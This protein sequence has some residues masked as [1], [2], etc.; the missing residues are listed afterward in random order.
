[1]Q[2]AAAAAG[3]NSS[4]VSLPANEW[5]AP[6][7]RAPA[8]EAYGSTI[9]SFEFE[10]SAEIPRYEV[11][12]RSLPGLGIAHSTSS[13]SRVRRTA[14]HLV[15]DDLVLRINLAGVRTL[16]QCG[17]EATVGP[18]EAVLSSGAEIS[19]ATTTESCFISFRVPCKPIKALVPDVEDRLCRTIAHETPT[20]RLL[21][22]YADALQDGP[23]ILAPGLQHLTVTHVYDLIALTLGATGEASEQAR[24]RGARAARL[25][26]IK[27]DIEQNLSAP[28][29][30]IGTVA[31]R[32]RLPVR[33]VQRLFEAEGATFTEFLL[34]RR[35]TRVHR[36]LSDP[37]L[38]DRPI[39]LLAFEAGFARQRYFNR[40]FRARFGAT[41][42]DIRAQTQV[43]RES[44]AAGE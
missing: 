31:E 39:S 11:K 20:L 19:A 26:E 9:W 2:Q 22:S 33:Y 17:R 21:T 1:M 36:L 16:A 27:Q 12:L 5:L 13:Q 24:M 7:C 43:V 18:G 28:E 40:S 8:W 35:L 14:Q 6:Q 41:P 34:E 29:L 10:R 23:A 25:R 42:S 4:V 3:R 37:H 15:N 44:E 38:L 32:H 30:C